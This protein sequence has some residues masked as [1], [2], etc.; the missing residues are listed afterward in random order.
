MTM[1]PTQDLSRLRL[2]TAP[3]S[4]GVWFPSD[5]HQVTWDVYLDEIARAGYLYTELGPQG[6]MPQDPERLRD[7]LA[8]RGLT[9]CGGTVFAGLHKG[10]DVLD[11][12]K[13]AFGQEARLLVAVGAKHL[14]HLPEQWTDMHTG[15]TVGAA[16]I[17]SAQW[18][19]LVSGT[20]ELGRFLLEKY[21]VELVF[22]PHVDTHV[23]TQP[24]IE[25]FLMDTDPEFVNLC[26]DTGHIAY[27]K[28][29]NID[30]VERFP[31]RT[32]YVHLKSVDPALRDRAVAENLPLSEA[33]KLGVMC[34]PQW[35]E[36]QMPVLLDVL[37]SLDRDIFC[38]VEQD[39]YPVEPD[40]PLPIGARMAGYYAACGLR[41]VRR[42]PS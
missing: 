16:E 20:N 37:A 22:H 27:C 42:W 11:V 17:D 12:A 35:G 19:N 21:G 39:L 33:V 5:P 13:E 25:R 38:V 24:R 23:D 32:T 3:D 8:Q 2:G 34:E 6:Y 26:L 36:P 30:I 18:S 4:W 29:D 15:K 28:G 9:C 40:I 1:L 7:E 14:V 10:K 31:D 41:P